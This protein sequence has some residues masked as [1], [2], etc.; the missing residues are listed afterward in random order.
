MSSP[1]ITIEENAPIT[2]AVKKMMDNDIECLIVPTLDQKISGILTF[3]D[4]VEK[5]ISLERTPTRTKVSE[6]MTRKVKTCHPTSTVSEV[7][8]LMKRN[9]LRR[10]PVVDERERLVGI[11]TT[12]D[13]AC[14]GLD[15]SS[16]TG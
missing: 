5:I 8:K 14:L 13:I 16:Q 1:V 12:F 11:V 7:V 4:I 10:V 15:I 3:R 2:E 6:I 9:R